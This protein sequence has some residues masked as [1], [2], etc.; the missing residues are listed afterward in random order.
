MFSPVFVPIVGGHPVDIT[1]LVLCPSGP[2]E[3]I[4]PF[5]SFFAQLAVGLFSQIIYFREYGMPSS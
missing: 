4:V 5:S 1:K 2:W 3:S